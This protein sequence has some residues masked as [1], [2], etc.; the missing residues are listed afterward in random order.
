MRA[1]TRVSVLLAGAFALASCGDNPT[2]PDQ[3]ASKRGPPKYALRVVNPNPGTPSAGG[4]LEGVPFTLGFS[5]FPPGLQYSFFCGTGAWT[6]WTSATSVLCPGLPNN[7]SYILGGRVRDGLGGSSV[8][9]ISIVVANVAPVFTFCGLTVNA[10]AWIRVG[11]IVGDVAADR[12]SIVVQWGD[13]AQTSATGIR[14]GA[15]WA[16]T[17]RYATRGDKVITVT[18]TD[19]EGAGA[20]CTINHHVS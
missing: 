2:T 6:P 12:A 4:L 7:G 18:I 9:R 15:L 16:P 3:T 10:N 1:V 13:G 8:T 17:H 11:V 20:I 5:S 14:P 19:P